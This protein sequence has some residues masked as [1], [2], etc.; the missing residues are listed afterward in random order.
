MVGIVASRLVEHFYRP[1]IV[2]TCSNDLVTGSARSVRDFDL[3]EALCKCSHLLE[4]FGGHTFAAGLSLKR[5]N[6][7]KFTEQFEQVVASSI[8]QKSIMP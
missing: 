4:H 7:E 1:A 8:S 5:E 3:Y 2:L 6:L